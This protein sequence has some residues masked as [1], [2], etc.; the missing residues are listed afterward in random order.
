MVLAPSYKR[1]T[2]MQAPL[3]LLSF[4]AG[5]LAWL[6]GGGIMWLAGAVLVGL[7]VPFTFLVIMPTNYQLLAPER[8]LTSAE[9]RALLEKWGTLHTVRSLLSLVASVIYVALLL[10]A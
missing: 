2:A 3:A 1:A 7:V 4:L 8:D 9:T 10:K 6:L 5:V